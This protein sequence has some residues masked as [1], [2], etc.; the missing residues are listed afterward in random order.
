MLGLGSN[1]SKVG[2]STPGIV[3]DNLVLKHKYDA[4]AVVP[5]SDGAVYFAGNTEDDYI[6][7]GSIS[8][9]TA[10]FSYG[11][12]FWINSTQG[13]QFA[14]LIS[15]ADYD[16]DHTEGTILRF[17]NNALQFINGDNTNGADDTIQDADFLTTTG[18]TNTWIHIYCTMSSGTTASLTAK[19]YINGALEASSTSVNFEPVS[20]NFSIGKNISTLNASAS[21]FSGYA[22]NVSLYSSELT[23]PQIKSIMW[24]NHAGLSTSDKTNLVSW[25]NLS[26]LIGPGVDW[27]GSNHGLLS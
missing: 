2:L 15:Q 8:L 27:H 19:F 23:Q 4:G 10:G 14:S 22:S 16:S 7:C 13:D 12:W 25:W 5:V 6:D 18:Y 20:S 21:A 24:K 26:T 1:L 3:T 11:G 17:N 9:G